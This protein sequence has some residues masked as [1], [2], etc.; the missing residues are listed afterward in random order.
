MKSCLY[1]PFKKDWLSNL[2]PWARNVCGKEN[3][4]WRI[5]GISSQN[6]TWSEVVGSSETYQH[7]TLLPCVDW[8]DA[9]L[10]VSS[11]QRHNTWEYS[12]TFHIPVSHPRSL[13]YMFSWCTLLAEILIHCF[14]HDLIRQDSRPVSQQTTLPMPNQLRSYQKK[15]VS[16]PSNV[17]GK[18]P[19]QR[20]QIVAQAYHVR[21]DH[22]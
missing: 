3:S 13:L 7:Y 18:L 2:S 12:L 10:W 5:Q 15:N 14:C 21:S 17:E 20:G 9:I 6:A 4:R 11:S 19:K 22:L 16:K 8:H 1:L